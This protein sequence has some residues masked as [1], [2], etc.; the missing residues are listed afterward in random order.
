MY[1]LDI[2]SNLKKLQKE[3]WQYY[4]TWMKERTFCKALNK[5][6]AITLK[7]WDHITK[8]N[9]SKKRNVKDKINRLQMLKQAKYIITNAKSFTSEVKNGET[10]IALESSTPKPNK[11]KVIIKKD[12]KGKL[13]FHSVMKH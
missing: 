7:G 10:Y 12:S 13:I 4:K 9:K 6:V 1:L 8:G 5:E 2:M 3:A 11:I